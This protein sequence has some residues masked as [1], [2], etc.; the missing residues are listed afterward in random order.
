M[1]K[2]FLLVL[3]VFT[4]TFISYA[5]NNGD[6]IPNR[7]EKN[8][9]LP[10][11]SNGDVLFSQKWA[12][13]LAQYANDR[14][15]WQGKNSI[16]KKVNS[17]SD[18]GYGEVW[19][20][21]DENEAI[22]NLCDFMV[23]SGYKYGVAYVKYEKRI[24]R[25]VLMCRKDRL[26][27]SFMDFFDT[28]HPA[29]VAYKQNEAAK[30]KKREDVVKS[31][32][33]T[34]MG[35]PTGSSVSSNKSYEQTLYDLRHRSMIIITHDIHTG[36]SF[37]F[38][39]RNIYYDNGRRVIDYIVDLNGNIRRAIGFGTT[40]LEAKSDIERKYPKVDYYSV[41]KDIRELAKKSL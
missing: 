36:K 5:S 28:T 41:P 30:Q 9:T 3:T 6:S 2:T 27:S 24:R 34:I 31:I 35:S 39:Y 17:E 20:N 23:E 14:T 12:G 32:A 37:V 16:I 26:R 22:K 18:L 13:E 8:V 21:A 33:K 10:D 19:H 4:Y 38:E 40:D 1:K 29:Y 7:V 25:Y 11:G 15:Q